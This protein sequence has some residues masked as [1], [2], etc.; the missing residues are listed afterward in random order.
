MAKAAWRLQ[1]AAG[2]AGTVL[3]VVV[4][5]WPGPSLLVLGALF[6]ICLVFAGAVQLAGAYRPRPSGHVQALALINGTLSL[7]LGLLC[8][9]SPAQSVLLLA[10]WIGFGWLIRGVS[11]TFTATTVPG[12]PDRR[13]QLCLGLIG[14]LAGILMIVSPFASIA[15]LTLVAGIWMITLGIAETAH[16]IRRGTRSRHRTH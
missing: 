11:Q 10:L 7:L 4:L 13:W 3:G 16:S 1:L 14:I 2:L 8:F 9:R 5:A 6:G 15:A 12:L